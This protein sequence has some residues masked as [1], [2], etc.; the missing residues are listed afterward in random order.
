MM[1]LG[2]WG[3]VKGHSAASQRAALLRACLRYWEERA[4]VLHC[5]SAADSDG[6]NKKSSKLLPRIALVA[7]ATSSRNEIES[8]KGSREELI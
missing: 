4:M 2:F 5:W 8:D 7:S 1:R 6:R 3:S